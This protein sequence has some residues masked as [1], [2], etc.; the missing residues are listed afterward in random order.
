MDGR[1]LRER[2]FSNGDG[3]KAMTNLILFL[4]GFLLGIFACGVLAFLLAVHRHPAPTLHRRKNRDRP[5]PER[6]LFEELKE[7]IG[8]LER[9]REEG[10]RYEFLG[11]TGMEE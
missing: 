2:Q 3:D 1:R 10:V 9:M 11:Q 6:N 5:I 4:A 7:G 8:E